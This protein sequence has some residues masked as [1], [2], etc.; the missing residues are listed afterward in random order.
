MKTNSGELET[1]TTISETSV[2]ESGLSL[3]MLENKRNNFHFTYYENCLPGYI[4]REYKWIG[5]YSW[6]II[7]SCMNLNWNLR[8]SRKL[9]NPQFLIAL[10]YLHFHSREKDYQDDIQQV[11][12]IVFVNCNR[13]SPSKKWNRG[14]IIRHSTMKSYC[15]T[16]IR[17]D[18]FNTSG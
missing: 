2:W 9:L 1:G 10:G 5:F 7:H 15:G 12:Q 11:D 6:I 18:I 14:K 13:D 16:R 3:T 17:T 4:Y 8:I